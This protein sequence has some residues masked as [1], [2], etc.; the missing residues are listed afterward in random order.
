MLLV[1][2][3]FAMI[4]FLPIELVNYSKSLLAATVSSSNFYFWQHS[5]YFDSPTSNPL[6][7]TW[8]LAVEEQFYILF[9]I[10]LLLIRRFFPNRLRTAVVVLFV[11]S[12]ITSAIVVHFSQNTAFYMPYTRAWE[13]LLGTILSLKMFPPMASL[14]LRNLATAVGAVMIAYSVLSYSSSTTFPGLSALVPCIGT[15]LII[16]AGESGSSIIGALLS[17]RPVVFIGLISYSLYLWHWPF[18]ILH[19]MGIIPL[20][21]FLPLQYDLA[22]RMRIS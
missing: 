20:A 18:I 6:L 3:I 15:A 21:S 1:F 17:W 4:Y 16:Q 12:L 10:F 14:W 19:D 13:L 22:L 2:T 9:P 5:G 7:H 11:L 8:S